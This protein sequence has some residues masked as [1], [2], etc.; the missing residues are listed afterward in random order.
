M[1]AEIPSQ[2]IYFFTKHVQHSIALKFTL[3]AFG[4]LVD[5]GVG[6]STDIANLRYGNDLKWVDIHEEYLK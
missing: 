2:H 5:K 4:G 3:L 6:T 1:V